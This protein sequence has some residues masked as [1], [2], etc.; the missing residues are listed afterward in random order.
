MASGQ[1]R[2]T[3]ESMRAR[4]TEYRV[5]SQ[6]VED[7]IVKMDTLLDNLMNEWEG[8]ASQAY[9]SKFAELRPSFVAAK[10]LIDDIATALTKTADAVEA[11]D[12]QIASQFGA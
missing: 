5:Q 6:N 8:A 7:V 2:M 3:P 12:N 9:A 4:A 1:I 11:T 10:D